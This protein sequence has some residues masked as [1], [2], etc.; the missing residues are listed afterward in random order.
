MLPIWITMSV[1]EAVGL[2]RW[3]C[4]ASAPT[5]A[6][7][8]P[9]LRSPGGSLLV[10]PLTRSGGVGGGVSA[11]GCAFF[12]KC[13]SLSEDGVFVGGAATLAVGQG[14]CRDTRVSMR[15]QLHVGLPGPVSY[16]RPGWV[17]VGQGGHP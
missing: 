16:V 1:T 9:T 14:L 7:G 3:G 10:L 11:P 12:W 8:L 2:W 4:C 15:V 5:G 13:A 17:C 6:H